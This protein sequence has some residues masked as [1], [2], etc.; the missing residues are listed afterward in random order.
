MQFSQFITQKKYSNYASK[1]TFQCPIIYKKIYQRF[2]IIRFNFPT[3]VF[4]LVNNVNRRLLMFA[5]RDTA[6]DLHFDGR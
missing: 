2:A 3:M 5:S 4:T 1:D 6:T